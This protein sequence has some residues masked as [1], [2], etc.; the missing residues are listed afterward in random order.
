MQIRVEIE[1]TP[2]ELRRFI[3][4]PDVAGLQ[5]D[6]I[7]YLRDKLGDV[8][9]S[10]RPG[11]FVR[12][13]LRNVRQSKAWRKLMDGVEAVEEEERALAAAAAKKAAAK[14]RSKQS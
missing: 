8:N 9:E 2:E 3:G 4:L 1:V 14:K 10:L 6:L 7:A 11:D 5:D 13:N 12:S